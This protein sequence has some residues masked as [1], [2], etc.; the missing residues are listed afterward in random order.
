[1][2]ISKGKFLL[3]LGIALV[4]I[5]QVIKVLVKTHMTIGQHIDVIGDWFKI[6]FIENEGMAFGMS[7]GGKVGK[8]LLS[9]FRIAL[10]GGLTYWVT[11]LVKKDAAARAGAGGD[12]GGVG[13]G[14]GSG[15]GSGAGA[16]GVSGS[17]T[18]AGAGAGGGADGVKG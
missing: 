18:S 5:D 11:R 17:G 15:V 3:I 1:M 2:K 4:V 13:S 8:F 12:D 14:A 16:G 6:Y 10:F 7:W 9:L